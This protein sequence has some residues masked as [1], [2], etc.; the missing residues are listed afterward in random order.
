MK[1][2]ILIIFL[3]TLVNLHNVICQEQKSDS[4]FESNIIMMAIVANDLDE[5][6]DFYT[7][8]IGMK[9]IAEFPVDEEFS[10]KSGLS[11]GVSFQ[12]TVL[13]LNEDKESS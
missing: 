2:K 6:L 13:Q 7:N 9:K 4:E 12:V 11:D 3:I 5:T 10:K 8:I 1:Q